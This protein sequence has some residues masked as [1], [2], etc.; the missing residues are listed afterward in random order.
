MYRMIRAILKG[1]VKL[2][3]S[4]LR[5][6]VIA[7]AC[8]IC[9]AAIVWPLWLLAS[10]RPGLYTILCGILCLVILLTLIITRLRPLAAARPRQYFLSVLRKLLVIGGICGSVTLVLHYQ[11]LAAL[12]VLCVTAIIYGYLAFALP[13]VRTDHQ[14]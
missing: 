6:T 5:Y 4:L 13:Q 11:R 3:R 9:A 7:L 2:I 14:R 10:T 12:L 1:Y 8:L